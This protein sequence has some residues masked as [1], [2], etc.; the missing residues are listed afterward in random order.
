MDRSDALLWLQQRFTSLY[1]RGGLTTDDEDEGFGPVIDSAWVLLEVAIGDEVTESRSIQ[2][3]AALNFSA[4]KR[5]ALEFVQRYSKSIAGIS[6]QTY[7]TFQ[8]ILKMLDLATKRL[9][10]VGLATPDG[11]EPMFNASYDDLMM[12]ARRGGYRKVAYLGG[13]TELG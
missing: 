6:I 12:P 11:M 3:E 13:V 5:I 9:V 4:L 1:E 2:Y 7:Q 10:V 8:G